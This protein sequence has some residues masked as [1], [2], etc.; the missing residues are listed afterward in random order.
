MSIRPSDDDKILF[1]ED[2]D[3]IR[4]YLIIHPE[5]INVFRNRSNM[6]PMTNAIKLNRVDI[7]DLLIDSGF[8]VNLCDFYG[9][10]P[11]HRAVENEFNINID[12]INRLIAA[13]ASGNLLTTRKQTP[14]HLAAKNVTDPSIIH[15]L[16]LVTDPNI[17]DEKGRT[18]L[19]KSCSHN[20]YDNIDI[21]KALCQYT[22]VNIQDEKGE[23][24]L[25]KACYYNCPDK[26]KILLEYGADPYLRSF[27]YSS[28]DPYYDESDNQSDDGTRSSIE[29]CEKFSSFECLDIIKNSTDLCIMYY[30]SC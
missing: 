13:G 2:I 27:P 9:Y 24:A 10:T 30:D 5:K 14:L 19:I 25:H 11:L 1:G 22:D 18:A 12:I 17:K 28:Y 21:V 20:I 26:V 15:L 4:K 23:T 6:S 29:T 16:Y 8:N 7:V 3:K